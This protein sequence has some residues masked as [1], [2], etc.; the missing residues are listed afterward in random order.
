MDYYHILFDVMA[1]KIIENRITHMIFFI[2]PHLGYDT[3]C[4]QIGKA[5]GLKI[6]ITIQSPF[7]NRYFSM[8]SVEEYGWLSRDEKITYQPIKIEPKENEWFYMKGIKQGENKKGKITLKA[9]GSIAK[10]LLLRKPSYLLNPFKLHSILKRTIDIYGELPEWRDP[11]AR[12][13]HT[14]ELEY[15][16]HI[17]QYEETSFDLNTDFVYFSLQMQPEMTT[18]A[19]GGW[20]RDQALAI[21]SLALLLPENVKIYVKENP[22]QGAYMRGPM[23]FHRLKRIPSVV[24]LPSFANTHALTDHS[25]FV[26]TISGTVGWE[27]VQKGKN[28]L[29]FGKTW[30]RSFPGVFEYHESLTYQEIM[31]YKIQHE[32]LEDVLGLLMTKSHK[33]VVDRH[34]APLVEEYDKDRNFK[35]VA[36]N[37]LGL[38]QG[39]EKTTFSDQSAG[40]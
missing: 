37:I 6:I 28:V 32:E 39:R 26:S 12:F 13:F 3:I 19:L 1:S 15:F 10:F 33:G 31:E 35:D 24:I 36:K 29:I 2:I 5:L 38:L 9:I 22:K 20:Y 25:L 21:E 18:S 4:Y 8:H 40:L 23:F 14:N 27:A 16:E 34:Y 17:T 11:F 7:P 30:Y